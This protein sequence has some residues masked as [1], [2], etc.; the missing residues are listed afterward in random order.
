MLIAYSALILTFACGFLAIG[1]AEHAAFKGWPCGEWLSR[2]DGYCVMTAGI[3]CLVSLA[4]A[5]YWFSWWSPIA[6]FAAGTAVSYLINVALGPGAQ[7][8]ACIGPTLGMLSLTVISQTVL[9]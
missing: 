5:F 3:A 8:P 9:K 4:T 7:I 6:V 1:Y 2:K